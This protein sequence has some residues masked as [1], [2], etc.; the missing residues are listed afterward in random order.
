[1]KREPSD[2]WTNAF[3]PAILNAWRANVDIQYIVDAYSA[4]M[5]VCSYVMKSEAKMSELLSRVA[6]ECRSETIQTQVKKLGDAFMSNR[7]V[8]AQESAYKILSIP[9]KQLSR[10][11]V[12]V[13]ADA[14]N[15]R[16][17]LLKPLNEIEGLRDEEENIYCTSI[18]D[19]Y[20][21]RPDE[22]REMCL[23][24]FAVNYEVKSSKKSEDSNVD[25][26]A[27]EGTQSFKEK[28]TCITLKI[29]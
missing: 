25:S 3:N 17:R 14:R 27:N 28:D 1:M 13:S 23:A 22:L 7:E 11:V 18:H 20:A 16:P 21:A 4:V 8:S 6:K 26:A 10:K 9:L 15:T 5:Y 19:R 29:T 2:I 12:F 24:E